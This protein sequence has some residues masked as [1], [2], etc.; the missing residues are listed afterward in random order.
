MSA[1]AGVV[2]FDAQP[3][4]SRTQQRVANALPSPAGSTVRVQY[5]SHAVF[6]QNIPLR[7]AHARG[8]LP[9]DRSGK[10]LFAASAHIDNRNEVA[11]PLGLER[12]GREAS[13]ADIVLRSIES[14]GDAGLARLVG[15]FAFAYWD[16]EARELMLGRDCL[17]F[18][19]LV[20]H[21]GRGFAAFA[22]TYNSLFALPDV[23]QEIDEVML[24]HFLALN[25]RHRRRT[26]YCGI[27]RVPSR[28]VVAING[29]GCAHREYWAP[30]LG[31]PPPYRTEDDYVARGRELLDQAVAIAIGDNSAALLMS[32]GLDSSG[33]AATAAR[34]GLGERLDCYTTVAPADSQV[35]FDSD[36]YSDDREKVEA[37][38]R[39]YPQLRLHFRVPPAN[40]PLDA[41]PTRHFLNTNFPVR[42]PSSLGQYDGLIAMATAKH[43]TVL[44]GNHGNLGLSWDGEDAMFDLFRTGRWIELIRE[45][46]AIARHDR[47]KITRTFYSEVVDRALPH[48]LRRIVYRLRGRDPD[49]VARF[50]AL[51]PAFIVEHNFA[52]Q[53]R[54]ENFDPWFGTADPRRG[55]ALRAY[56]IFDR[57]QFG[58]DG[59]GMQ[60]EAM[61]IARRSPLGD[62][63]LLEF[64]L[65]VPE[66][67]F[68]S[69]GVPRSFA[70]RVLADR[71]PREIVDERRRGIAETAWFRPLDAQRETIGRDLERI[72]AS[73][74]ASRMLDI[75]RL[76]RL[77]DDWPKDEQAA[78]LRSRDYQRVFARGIHVGR[79]IRWV[80]GGNA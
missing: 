70:R 57:N 26:I 78:Q 30:N 65:S 34:L 54:A 18:M 11:A 66:P 55:A 27:E 25:L 51:N 8:P 73:P 41:D 4:D 14:A 31:A 80:E 58:R 22:S 75:P 49:S 59:L 20:F 23:P 79:F 9:P 62:R 17:G 13:D 48:R 71:L 24:G 32:G 45:V 29:S 37:L 56:Y 19:P 44:D 61:G 35:K 43:R 16:C 33:V 5:D 60:F 39:M 21:V 46:R 2:F 63:R 12:Q 6:A 77:L 76:R 67:M 74:L 68:R 7:E 10:V 1:F 36:S 40:H 64:V 42:N 15:A 47:R 69:N 3:I 50:S 38:A 52:A 28:S 53:F 72:A